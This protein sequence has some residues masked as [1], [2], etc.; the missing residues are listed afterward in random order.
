MLRLTTKPSFIRRLLFVTCFQYG[1]CE[2]RIRLTE[3]RPGFVTREAAVP[4]FPT[5]IG[6]T[7]SGRGEN[8]RRF[9]RLTRG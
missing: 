3:P 6:R 9:Q 8:R 7:F 5:H 4:L 1:R 2:V